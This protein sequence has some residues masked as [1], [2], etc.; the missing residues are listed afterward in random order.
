MTE[1]TPVRDSASTSQK[2]LLSILTKEIMRL[3]RNFGGDTFGE[4][5][6]RCFR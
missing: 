2:P 4:N 6:S 1:K 3:N 5:A